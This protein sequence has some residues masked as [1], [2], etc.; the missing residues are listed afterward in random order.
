MWFKLQTDY[1]YCHW[2]YYVREIR[3]K[4][5]IVMHLEPHMIYLWTIDWHL[6]DNLIN[7]VIYRENRNK[8]QKHVQLNDLWRHIF[9]NIC[10]CP[11]HTIRVGIIRQCFLFIYNSTSSHQ[12]IIE[13]NEFDLNTTARR[14][15]SVFILDAQ[16]Y[17]FKAT[18]MY[19][20]QF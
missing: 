15:E 12:I 18:R 3:P 6:Q 13:S 20:T 1:C 7:L 5:A 16:L 17:M 19:V 11:Q 4:Q 14:R 2:W 9:E 10:N 8:N